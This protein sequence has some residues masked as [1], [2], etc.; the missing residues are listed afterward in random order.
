MIMIEKEIRYESVRGCEKR[1]VH[2]LAAGQ[3]I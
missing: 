2:D 3:E 1:S